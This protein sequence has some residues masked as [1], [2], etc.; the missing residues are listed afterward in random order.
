VLRQ[1]NLHDSVHKKLKEEFEAE[2]SVLEGEGYEIE[3]LDHVEMKV[4]ILFDKACDS[5]GS[6]GTDI[7]RRVKS[8]FGW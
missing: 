3:Y 7:R 2:A 6:L 4:A 5:V 8:Y 1:V